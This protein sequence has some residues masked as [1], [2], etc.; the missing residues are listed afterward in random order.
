MSGGADCF[1]FIKG[2]LQKLVEKHWFSNS[3]LHKHA[4]EKCQAV[5]GRNFHMLAFYLARYWEVG[6]VLLWSVPAHAQRH[7][8]LHTCLSTHVQIPQ[9]E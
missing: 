8:Q 7:V 4:I 2:A 9:H 6:A 1:F 5:L 3:V